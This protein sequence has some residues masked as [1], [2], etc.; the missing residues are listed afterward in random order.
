M[1]GAGLDC[2]DTCVGHQLDTGTNDPVILP[3]EN[4]R[5]VHLGQLAERCRCVDHIEREA[6]G[7]DL[8]DDLVAAKHDQGPG[9]ASQ[10]PL[11]PIPQRSSGRH[12]CEVIQQTTV[13]IEA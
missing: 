13:P 6:T 5:S 9:T 1:P 12:H 3:V 10:D 2:L 7:G 4:D 8:R 11:K